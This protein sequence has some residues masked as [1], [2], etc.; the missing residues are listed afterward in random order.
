MTD[1]TQSFLKTIL[2][3]NP[4]T[5]IFTWKSRSREHFRNDKG[6]RTFHCRYSNKKA[7]CSRKDGYSLICI[8]K[9]LFY[10][11]RLAWLYMSG[12]W[13]ENIDHINRNPSDNRICNLREVTRQENSR[14]LKLNINNTSGV[15]GVC[16]FKRDQL[17]MVSI[18]NMSKNMHL[19]YF[20]SFFDA[21]CARRSAE[22]NLGY[23][24][25]HG[26]LL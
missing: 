14:N 25:N 6:W 17:W 11:H 1:I 20:E 21:V 24:P 5:G 9:K 15:M 12:E 2:K 8:G 7:G 4:D 26:R 22:N 13:A 10:A 16:W 23:H 18:R 19:G 3:Y